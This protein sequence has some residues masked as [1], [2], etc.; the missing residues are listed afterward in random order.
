MSKPLESLPTPVSHR[1]PRAMYFLLIGL[2]LLLL[3][4]FLLTPL[5]ILAMPFLLAGWLF[6]WIVWRAVRRMAGRA[7][8]YR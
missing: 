4:L 2:P 7:R 1:E 6:G 5:G 3:G 8:R